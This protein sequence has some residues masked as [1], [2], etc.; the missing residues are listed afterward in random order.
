VPEDGGRGFEL[1]RHGERVEGLAQGIDRKHLLR[2]RR[3]E[4]PAERR[5]DLHGLR[6]SEAR[7]ELQREL[8]EASAAGERCVL[9]IHGRGLHSESGPVLREGVLAWLTSP[10]LARRVM[11]FASA[12][13]RDGGPG[14]SYVLLRRTRPG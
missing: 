8:S 7:R 6:A 5:V 2:L 1:A 3:G 11:A 12:L 4:W 9:V 13:P 10:P 14:A